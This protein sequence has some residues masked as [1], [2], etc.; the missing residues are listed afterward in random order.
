MGIKLIILLLTFFAITPNLGFF[1]LPA[2]IIVTFIIANLVLLTIKLK[3]IDKFNLSDK[4]ML[5]LLLYLLLTYSLI[6][7]GGLYQNPGSFA[8]AQIILFI[9]IAYSFY[10]NL[11]LN[12]KVPF[13]LIILAYAILAVWTIINSPFPQVDSFVILK[14]APL[15]LLMGINPYDSL[16]TKIYAGITPNYYNYLPFSF[17]T[18]LPSVLIFGDPRYTII[19]GNILCAIIFQKIFIKSRNDIVLNTFILSYLF[20]PRSFYILEHMYLDSTIFLFFILTIYFYHK[21][22]INFALLSLGICLLF[23]Q[24]I[25]IL[26]PL[27]LNKTVFKHIKARNIIYIFIPFLLPLYFLIRNPYAFI[28][29]TIGF[30]NPLFIPV[31]I[32]YSLTLYGFA[33]NNINASGKAMGGLIIA[34]GLIFI[35]IYLF[36]LFKRKSLFFSWK[37]SLAF[38]F[39]TFFTYYG[40]YNH[41]YLIAQFLLLDIMFN[42]FRLNIFN[43]N[44]LL[45]KK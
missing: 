32:K 39:F 26:L 9:I 7:Y 41:Y 11:F 21:K 6:Y 12:K 35:V 16:Y 30:F 22:N 20:L 14:E 31:P 4:N 13:L 25:L 15:K 1:T 2:F 28:R 38:Y 29:N 24:H 33:Q 45:A 37:I 17:I 44:K 36:I 23:K 18:T 19:F 8:F 43:P 5:L 3:L 10:S 40:F 34:L 27:L 42:Y